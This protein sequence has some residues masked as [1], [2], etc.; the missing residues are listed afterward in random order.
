MG[1]RPYRGEVKE[2]EE[3]A[4]QPKRGSICRAGFVE[5]LI[6]LAVLKYMRSSTARYNKPHLALEGLLLNHLFPHMRREP[7]LFQVYPGLQPFSQAW[8][9]CWV[10]KK[11]YGKN[12]VKYSV[13][14][15]IV[16]FFTV[17]LGVVFRDPTYLPSLPPCAEV[18]KGPHGA[19]TPA[20]LAAM[21][22]CVC[23]C[24]CAP[25]AGAQP[26]LQPAAICGGLFLGF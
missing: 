25:A 9:T 16:T 22:V 24:V 17:F 7:M 14:H 21:C 10:A 19:Q 4:P 20:R 1:V 6:R 2:R 3:V 5:C 8:H 12:T 11:K 18:G 15:S 26:V 13:L 23:V